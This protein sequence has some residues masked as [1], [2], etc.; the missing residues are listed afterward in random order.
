MDSTLALVHQH[1]QQSDQKGQSLRSE[2]RER[3]RERG[4]EKER[5][6]KR[7]R[8]V[9]DGEKRREKGVGDRVSAK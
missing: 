8:G 3:E 9:E 1:K 5:E 7:I 2:E 4:W 6:S